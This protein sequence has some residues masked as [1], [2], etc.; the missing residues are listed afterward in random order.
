MITSEVAEEALLSVFVS[1]PEVLDLVELDGQSMFEA[2]GEADKTEAFWADLT[3]EKAFLA[4]VYG[5]HL[6][7]ANVSLNKLELCTC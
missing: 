7:S 4:R 1:R 3:P 2:R 6:R 5:E